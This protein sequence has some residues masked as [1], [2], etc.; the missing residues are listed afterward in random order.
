[1]EQQRIKLWDLPTRL[2]HWL[3]V[4]LIAAAMITGQ[5]GGSAIEWHGKIG[6]AILGLITFRLTW[7]LIGSSHARFANFFPTP[8]SVRAYL[9]GQWKGVGHNPLGSFSVFGLLA[10]ITLQV[11]TGLLG[12]DDIAF[13]GPLSGLISKALSDKL[14]G[15]HKLSSNLLIALIALHLAAI[16]FYVH[17]KKDNLLKPMITGWKEVKP[18][19]G[20]SATGGGALVFI[21]A[22][23]I[24][25]AV[26]YGGSGAWIP[27]P[28]PVQVPA[29]TW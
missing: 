10:L 13:N 23:I 21:V 25:L 3:L 29:A 14:T 27:A 5:V 26:V 9:Q 24:A 15:L 2:F 16:L 12:N 20:K 22:L 17:I 19:E 18:G 1:V 11:T 8:S 4:I 6:L 7:G 28:P